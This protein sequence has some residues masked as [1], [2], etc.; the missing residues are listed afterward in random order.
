LQLPRRGQG[1]PSIGDA[2]TVAYTIIVDRQY[3]LASELEHQHHLHRPRTDTAHHG[4][5]LDDLPIGQQL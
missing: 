4:Q 3:I 1:T 5:A 2:K